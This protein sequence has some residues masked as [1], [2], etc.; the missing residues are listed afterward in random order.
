MTRIGR[1]LLKNAALRSDVV[2]AKHQK[3]LL[4]KARGSTGVIANWRPGAGKTPGAIAVAEDRGG[5]TVVVGP[6]A[7]RN[8][9]RDSVTRF[10]TPD[11]HDQYHVYSYEQFAK[12]PE[13]IIDRHSPKTVIF[14]E[15]HRLRNEGNASR[16]V[17]KVRHR[18]PFALGLTGSLVNNH[19]S[20]IAP[21]VNLVS[22]R[23]V[24]QDAADFNRQHIKLVDQRP[25]SIGEL[26]LRRDPPKVESV[27][28]PKAVQQRV[29]PYVHRY[30]GD[31]NFNKN[32]PRVVEEQIRVPMSDGQ[33]LL[34]QNILKKNPNFARKVKENLPPSK[35]D[36]QNMNAFSLAVRQISNT[37]ES[38]DLSV[39]D[40]VAASPKFK[41][42]IEEQHRLAA[43]DTEFRSVVYSSF[44]NSGV[45][46]VTKRLND[47]GL[48]ATTFQGGMTDKKRGQV[49]RDYNEGRTRVL[50]ISPA[51]GEGLDLKGVRL[52][53]MTEDHWNPERDTQVTARGIRF[54]SHAHLPESKREVRVQRFQSTA[55]K[56]W[57][58]VIK[59]PDTT[60]DEWVTNR[61]R[62]KKRLNE[63]ALSAL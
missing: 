51:G 42:M 25:R 18:I 32:F 54:K 13:T 1:L 10:T 9:F 57:W 45:S 12:S 33:W 7:L 21:I 59:K 30:M 11:R 29:G 58:H 37:P 3:E 14:D 49:V 41:R 47:T 24:Y 22:G 46:P 56:R 19:P 2:L 55:P 63:E 53:Q 27:V 52:L 8:N 39:T 38:F 40:A 34:Y 48:K 4:Q 5:T 62:E 44:L 15:V 43:N 6:A 17:E 26:L 50:G 36:L 16:A 28:N 35:N 60:I 20:E 23:Q 31:E 61:Q